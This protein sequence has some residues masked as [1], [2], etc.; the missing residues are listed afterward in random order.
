MF[1]N[2]LN[3]VTFLMFNY[4]NIFSLSYMGVAE[5]MMT[6]K[7]TRVNKHENNIVH[8]LIIYSYILDIII[9]S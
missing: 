6:Y 3:C 8:S 5:I 7:M 1:I 4:Y 2:T 9:A